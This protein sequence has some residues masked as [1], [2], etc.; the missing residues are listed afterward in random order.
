MN[1]VKATE[2]FKL[3]VLSPLTIVDWGLEVVSGILASSKMIAL[4][5]MC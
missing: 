5:K 4:G 3:D 1:M 2:L